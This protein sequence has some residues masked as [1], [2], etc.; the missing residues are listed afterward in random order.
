MRWRHEGVGSNAEGARPGAM[1]AHA[2]HTAY[3]GSR[4]LAPSRPPALGLDGNSVPLRRLAPAAM[5][6]NEYM[7]ASL[8]LQVALPVAEQV[9]RVIYKFKTQILHSFRNLRRSARTPISSTCPLKLPVAETI[10]TG[11]I[12]ETFSTQI[13]T[14]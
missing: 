6:V 10:R 2:Q 7:S 9:V 4:G 8:A 14:L 13:H 5:H 12:Q 11:D 1:H 3:R